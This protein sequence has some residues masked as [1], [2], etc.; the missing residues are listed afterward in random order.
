[1]IQEYIFIEQVNNKNSQIKYG[2][3]NTITFWLIKYIKIPKNLRTNQKFLLKNFPKKN[4]VLQGG[5]RI[6][7]LQLNT[8][9]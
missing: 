7:D 8:Q 5:F 3:I 6:I 9:T 1:M 2:M 4:T